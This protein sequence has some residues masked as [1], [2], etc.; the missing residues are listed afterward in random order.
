[1]SASKFAIRSRLAI[2]TPL[3]LSHSSDYFAAEGECIVS[4]G[5]GV[6]FGWCILRDGELARRLQ[7]PR[8]EDDSD[9]GVSCSMLCAALSDRDLLLV[10][11][12]AG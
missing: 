5:P 9:P 1:M 7:R 10:R 8:D 4:A 2:Y 12:L 11:G 6:R 3:C